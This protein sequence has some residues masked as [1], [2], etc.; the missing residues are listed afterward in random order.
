MKFDPFAH[1]EK[2][3]EKLREEKWLSHDPDYYPLSV[4]TCGSDLYVFFAPTFRPIGISSKVD[5]EY[6]SKILPQDMLYA[7]TRTRAD[8]LK[9]IIVIKIVKL[10]GSNHAK[11]WSVCGPAVN[12][13]SLPGRT[14]HESLIDQAW[15]S[16]SSR[17]ACARDIF[18]LLESWVNV[19]G[20]KILENGRKILEKRRPS[21]P[22]TSCIL[23]DSI[24]QLRDLMDLEPGKH[25]FL[26]ASSRYVFR[27]IA[28]D[29]YDE[30]QGEGHKLAEDEELGDLIRRGI[31]AEVSEA[32][33]GS[34]HA[35]PLDAFIDW[36][37]RMLEAERWEIEEEP[38]QESKLD[39]LSRELEERMEGRRIRIRPGRRRICR[40]LGLYSPTERLVTLF[41]RMWKLVAAGA[42]APSAEEIGV[43]TTLHEFA[44]AVSHVSHKEWALQ[45]F[46]QTP[47]GIH[48]IIA[49]RCSLKILPLYEDLLPKSDL[50]DVHLW[51][52]KDAPAEYRFW[53]LLESVGNL[54]FA[55]ILANWR[56]ERRVRLDDRWVKIPAKFLKDRGAGLRATAASDRALANALDDLEHAFKK[57]RA[58]PSQFI[59]P[60]T[61]GRSVDLEP[62]IQALE[63]CW[64]QI[65]FGKSA[66]LRKEFSSWCWNGEELLQLD[67]EQLRIRLVEW[68]V[69]LHAGRKGGSKG[70]GVAA[71]LDPDDDDWADLIRDVVSEFDSVI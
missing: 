61:G 59:K 30:K 1:P 22:H 10:A 41:P 43:I 53:K 26:K 15:E 49:E 11:M 25:F 70:A 38:E 57:L 8:L 3:L 55:S 71:I 29:F 16:N 28:D 45:D 42:G 20:R 24:D 21:F 54:G 36:L 23:F 66:A 56:K 39:E 19:R 65:L 7:G 18:G 32:A 64:E 4:R 63:A 69:A 44:H 6:C 17:D 67:R 12:I 40:L 35:D 68:L 52:C 46:I 62:V 50:P 27:A 51:L 48:E 5:A 31:E 60:D 37:K 13:L 33:V 14:W 47:V 34:D 2:L 9:E 58:L